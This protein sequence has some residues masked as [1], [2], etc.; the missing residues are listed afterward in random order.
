MSTNLIKPRLVYVL[1]EGTLN[2]P[3]KLTENEIDSLFEHYEET[4]WEPRL[5]PLY[6]LIGCNLVER[7]V[8]PRMGTLWI[9]EEG[10]LS[11]RKPNLLAS[12]FY[13]HSNHT[14]E[15]IVGPAVL[16]PEDECLPEV[17]ERDIEGLWKHWCN[18]RDTRAVSD[19]GTA[20]DSQ[21]KGRED[22]N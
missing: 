9:D 21:K 17:V 18:H 4:G 2:P 11:E 12:L 15:N 1:S 20:I 14:S 19:L 5:Q 3:R 6:E 10:R 16:I 13:R 7:V 22:L 8:L